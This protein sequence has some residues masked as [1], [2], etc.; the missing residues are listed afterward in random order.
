MKE[1]VKKICKEQ[2]KTLKELASDIGI[3]RESLTRALNGNP[4]IGTLHKIADALNVELW[5][6]FTDSRISESMNDIHGVVW[7][8]GKP[9]IINTPADLETLTKLV[10]QNEF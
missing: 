5:E 9:N 7:F 2:G 8:A 4:T 1:K 6:L 10:T 3:A